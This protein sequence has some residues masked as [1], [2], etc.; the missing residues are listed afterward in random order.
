MVCKGYLLATKRSE[1]EG[2]G[3]TQAREKVNK[4]AKGMSHKIAALVAEISKNIGQN[5]AQSLLEKNYSGFTGSVLLEA[6]RAAYFECRYP[7]APNPFY[8]KFPFAG[9]RGF[10]ED[11]VYSSGLHQFCYEF[12]RLIL[13][14]LKSKFGIRI[15]ESW[16]NEKISGDEGQRFVNLFFDSRKQDFISDI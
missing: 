16:L 2:L 10:Y 14:N 13:S 1:Y 5:K 4:L 9:L 8:E 3:K 6:I 7:L 15:P 11:P 12:C